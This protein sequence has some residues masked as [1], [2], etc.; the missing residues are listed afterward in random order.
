MSLKIVMKISV[1][2]FIVNPP[3]LISCILNWKNCKIL[4]NLDNWGIFF[5][6]VKVSL[7]WTFGYRD[8]RQVGQIISRPWESHL[9]GVYCIYN[10]EIRGYN[11]FFAIRIVNY[12]ISE[13]YWLYFYFRIKNGK[14]AKDGYCSPIVE[15]LQLKCRYVTQQC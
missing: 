11:F 13:L 15:P 8:I 1:S 12:G 2:L 6:L 4:T 7:I 9:R 3:V 10:G 14:M 5:F